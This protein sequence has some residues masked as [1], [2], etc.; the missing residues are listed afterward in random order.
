M[1]DLRK[2]QEAARE[3]VR[4]CESEIQSIKAAL[5]RLATSD[6]DEEPNSMEIVVLK[7]RWVQLN[8]FS[9][10]GVLSSYSHLY[11]VN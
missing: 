4:K 3:D 7:V 1:S 8:E 9:P 11:L 5:R 10:C 2:E 6:Q